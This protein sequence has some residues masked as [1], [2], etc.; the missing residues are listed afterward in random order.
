[1]KR[2]I[3]TTIGG[4]TYF[5][6]GLQT[7]AGWLAENRCELISRHLCCSDLSECSSALSAMA[8]PVA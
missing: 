7:E 5:I 2:A 4:V 6:S 3:G 8:C 1:M